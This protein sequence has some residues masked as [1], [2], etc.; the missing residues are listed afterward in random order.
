LLMHCRA[1]SVW[2]LA[3]DCSGKPV[4]H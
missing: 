2:I 1:R 4:F 3:T